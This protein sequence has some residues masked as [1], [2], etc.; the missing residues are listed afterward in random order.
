MDTTQERSFDTP[1]PVQ[2]VVELGS[3]NVRTE[4]TETETSTVT[5]TGPRAEEFHI[6]LR[7]RT[8]SVV[9]PKTMG[10]F[11][12]VKGHDVH[13][14]VPT[15]SDLITKTGSAETEATGT[16]G[17]VRVKTG[18][19]G[20]EIEHASEHLIIDAGSGDLRCDIAE[21]HVR[22]RSG[23]GDVELGE[24]RGPGAISTGSGSI[25]L[26][27]ADDKLVVKTG[28]GDAEVQRS[29]GDIVL[30]TGSGSLSVAHAERGSIRAKTGS[31]DVSIGIAAN[32]PVW[33]D[34]TTGSGRIRSDLA[35]V[36]KPDENQ[37]HVELRLQTGSGD[38]T[39]HQ[40]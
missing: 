28:S 35:P 12:S 33:T 8:L 20:V 17:T 3:G 7:G 15:G 30:V 18:S 19:G 37:D 38:I 29:T 16:Y 27:R 21:K 10:V 14:V 9:P 11:G 2:L 39:L 24:V 36:G 4:A 22:A 1:D 23:S 31:G 6:D 26:G 40:V 13:V 34:V 32:T 25:T 5:V